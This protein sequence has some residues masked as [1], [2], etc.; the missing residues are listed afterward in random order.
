MTEGA[1]EGPLG[2]NDGAHE[3]RGSIV[4]RRILYALLSAINTS[5]IVLPHIPPGNLSSAAVARLPSPGEGNEYVPPVPATTVIT[6][7]DA[8]IR[9]ILLLSLSAMKTLPSLSAH[10]C[11]GRFKLDNVA[12]AGNPLSPAIPLPAN[13]VIMPERAS[14]DLMR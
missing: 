7:L 6:P 3:G 9:L 1:T 13:V 2:A 8:A 11:L 5:P 10:V 4:R 12:A 14:T